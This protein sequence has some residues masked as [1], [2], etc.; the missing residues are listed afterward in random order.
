MSTQCKSC[1]ETKPMSDFYKG[2]LSRD[3]RVG[4]CKECVKSDVRANRLVNLD[5][6]REYDRE[7]GNRLPK[8]YLRSYR[9]L[10]PAKYKAHCAVS[11]AVRDGRLTKRDSCEG[12]GSEL[13]IHGHHDDYSKPLDVRWLCAGC[14]RQWHIKNGEGINGDLIPAKRQIHA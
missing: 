14:H 2:H 1:S 4:K 3:C 13:S 12:C 10:N 6:Y 5:Y 7:R 8:S 11:N 9:T